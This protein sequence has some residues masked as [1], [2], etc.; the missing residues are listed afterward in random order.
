VGAAGFAE[1]ATWNVGAAV[2]P[3]SLALDVRVLDDRP[4][5]LDL[6]SLL[7]ASAVPQQGTPADA[8]VHSE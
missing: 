2:A 4:P 3:G 8:D 5:F 1:R 6:G 7:A